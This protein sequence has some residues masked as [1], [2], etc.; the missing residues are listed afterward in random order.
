MA[1]RGRFGERHGEL[2]G[3]RVA[4]DRERHAQLQSG[5][6]YRAVGG[7]DDAVTHV[8]ACRHDGLHDG[9]DHGVCHRQPGDA[10]DHVVAGRHHLWH[11]RGRFGEWH[12]ESWTVNGSPVTVSG[13]PSYS[14]AGT[15]VPSAGTTTL[16]LTFTPSDTTDYTT[17]T[18][19]VSLTV[20]QA[21]PTIT[22]T[23]PTA[24]T[25][26]TPLGSS[27]LDATSTVAGTYTYNPLPGSVLSAGNDQTL[28][29][30]LTPTDTTDYTD[31]T[32][33]VSINV[34][35][36]NA[37]TPT[38][39]WATPSNHHLWDAFEQFAI[40][41]NVDGGGVVHLHSGAERGGAGRDGYAVGDVQ[42]D[43]H[44]GLHG[45]DD[46]SVSHRQPGDADDHLVAGRH[47]LW[48]L[49]WR[50]SENATESWTVNGSP[51]TVAA[52]PATVRRGRPCRRRGRRRCLSPSRLRTRRITRRRRPR[53]LSPS[54]G[55]RRRSTWSPAAITYGTSVG[56]S[57]NATES[58]TV[59]GSPVT[60]SG[61]PS[62]SP[63][64]T[65]VPSAGTTTLSLTFTP[66]DT[67]DY[68]TATTYGFCHRQ[69]GDADD[70]LV[71]GQPSPMALRWAVR[72]ATE[73]WTVNGR[74]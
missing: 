21:T 31:A 51:V 28:S 37:V 18:T 42:S 65:T 46:H 17:A 27:Q 52:R 5:G 26:G 55:R 23:T 60:V 39:T 57:E 4:G 74:R 32:T 7:D 64:G 50:R 13:T 54:T 20:N 43:G 62:Y 24:I 16:S 35:S 34:Y 69:S 1:L 22:W 67:T 30:T 56:G 6:N 19:S 33:S 53:C 73:S 8:H 63:A 41:C 47:H 48:H 66:S 9:D 25:Y 3:E 40:G 71:A 12:T 49:R 59:N 15:T 36:V 61:T 70:H 68:T 10:D 72:S 58:W 14:P 11:Y 2:D 45:G 38:I 44:D 29:V